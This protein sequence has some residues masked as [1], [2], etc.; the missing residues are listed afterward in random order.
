[1]TPPHDLT[2]LARVECVFPDLAGAPRGKL[3]RARQLMD[4][5]SLRMARAIPLQ[6]VCGGYAAD[7][8]VGETDS[9]MLL[10]PD[11][12]TL[13][14]LPWALDTGWLVHDCLNADGLA[15]AY[16]PRAVLHSVLARYA[17]HGWRPI[18]AAEI[19]FYLFAKG[20][21]EAGFKQ[22]NLLGGGREFDMSSAYGADALHRLPAFWDALFAAL[23]KLSIPYDTWLHEMGPG[24]YELNL[25]HGDALAAAD[26]VLLFKT[27]LRQIAARHELNA[28][29]MAKPLS[30]QPGSS[31]HLH[32]S[33]ADSQG[34]NIFSGASGEASS[35]FFSFIAGLQRYLAEMLAIFAPYGNSWR[36]YTL[37]ASAPLRLDWGEDNR[38]V[39]LRSPL[40]SALARRIENRVAGADANPYLA[41]AASLACG[42]AGIEEQLEAR[43]PVQD[44]HGYHQKAEICG[45]LQ[46]AVTRL[47]ESRAARRLLGDVFVDG[48]CSVKEVE[49]EHEMN[50]VS[51][52]ERRYLSGQV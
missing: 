4:G 51:A 24:Q 35:E 31:M 34:R 52:W 45:G 15:V 20:D 16:T 8:V 2:R 10:S 37:S 25:N 44:Q 49:I 27:A 6:A 30:G 41:I 5:Q 47:R 18:V 48:F 32:Q 46:A 19:E 1:M 21:A 43:A 42:L 36:R 3:M 12:S 7:T 40:A 11:W 22:T 26:Q 9:D 23:D 33:V 38:T 17:A 39:A 14:T 13:R 29:F 50:E 28:V